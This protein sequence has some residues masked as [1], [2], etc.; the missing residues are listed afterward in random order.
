MRRQA[1]QYCP[2]SVNPIASAVTKLP[3]F[4]AVVLC[5]AMKKRC[6]CEQRCCVCKQS[7][8]DVQVLAWLRCKV[9]VLRNALVDSSASFAGLGSDSLTIYAVGL[10]GEFLSEEWTRR[11]ADSCHVSLGK[12]PKSCQERATLKGFKASCLH[13]VRQKE[14][15]CWYWPYSRCMVCR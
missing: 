4:L 1:P 5:C 9:K 7:R 15:F 11:L 12:P 6:M 10:L 3:I 2:G 8:G 13:R 14:R